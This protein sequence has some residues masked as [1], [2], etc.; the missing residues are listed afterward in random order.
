MPSYDGPE[1]THAKETPDLGGN[2]SVASEVSFY[3]DEDSSSTII[4]ASTE[5]Q[6]QSTNLTVAP[7]KIACSLLVTPEKNVTANQYSLL[8]EM[9]SSLNLSVNSHT[10]KR[11]RSMGSPLTNLVR[12]ERFDTLE[13]GTTHQICC[14][15]SS[16]ATRDAIRR[17]EFGI[18]RECSG[19]N[20]KK[21]NVTRFL[22]MNNCG[23]SSMLTG[24]VMD[25][26]LQI[27]CSE[28]RNPLGLPENH[29]Y[30]TCSL[31]LS[32]KA[33]LISLLKERLDPLATNTPAGIPVV[34]SDISSVNQRLCIKNLDGTPEQGIWCQADGCVFNT[35]FCPFCRTPDN[36][37]GV[38]IVATDSSN[39]Q[40][41]NKVEFYSGL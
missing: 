22:T 27:F 33:H 34:I 10:Q 28:C 23:M 4:Q 1:V 35:I 21:P 30:V 20:C 26:K 41:L 6:D 3:K 8:P 12:S 15:E 36:C 13:A 37:L 25:N 40:L 29:L 38:Q 5:F 32:S 14:L 19:H 16:A 31:T 18:E 24:P 11:R 39:V 9:E 17:I 7:S 2:M